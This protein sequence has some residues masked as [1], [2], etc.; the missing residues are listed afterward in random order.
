MGILDDAMVSCTESPNDL[1]SNTTA[2]NSSSSHSVSRMSSSSSSGTVPSKTRRHGKR[3]RSD[4]K[5]PGD[6]GSESDEDDDDRRRGKKRTAPDPKIPQ[7]RLRCPFYLRDPDSGQGYPNMSRLHTKPCEIL[8]EPEDDRISSEQW[9][10]IQSRRGGKIEEK[11][12]F[13]FETLFPDEKVKPS[14]YE[15]P[16]LMS[17]LENILAVVLE[18][19]LAKEF[20]PIVASFKA[21]MPTIIQDCRNRL[22]G[23]V[24]TPDSSGLS[25]EGHISE[26]SGPLNETYRPSIQSTICLVGSEKEDCPS[27]THT[28]IMNEPGFDLEQSSINPFLSIATSTPSSPLRR[29]LHDLDPTF[30][31]SE[32]LEGGASLPL[33]QPEVNWPSLSFSEEDSALDPAW[34]QAPR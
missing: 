6:N 15:K 12:T 28:G 14:P 18:E 16:V 29:F 21:R 22:Q 30:V 34:L 9:S 2:E 19:E 25:N 11:W 8:P 13:L 1:N 4:G 20:D 10:L 33:Q 17:Q 3:G 26:P 7:K 23:A 32:N 24:V 5:D 31:G 27:S